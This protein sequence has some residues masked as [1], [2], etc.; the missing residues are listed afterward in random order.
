MPAVPKKPVPKEKVPPAIPKKETTPPAK[1][2]LPLHCPCQTRTLFSVFRPHYLL[3]NMCI[4]FMSHCGFFHLFVIESFLPVGF[5]SFVEN[6][7]VTLK[8]V[9]SVINLHMKIVQKEI[10]FL[11]LL[12]R[13][14]SRIYFLICYSSVQSSKL[15]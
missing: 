14:L 2:T 7:R 13:N 3:R 9:C 5:K 15:T 1:G 10:I 6:V 4:C 12:E 11:F 8:N